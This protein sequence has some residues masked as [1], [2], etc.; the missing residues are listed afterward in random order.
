MLALRL[1]RPTGCAH[2][3]YGACA[4]C[5][6]KINAARVRNCAMPLH[7]ASGVQPVNKKPLRRQSERSGFFVA[8][9]CASRLMPVI[10]GSSDRFIA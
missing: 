5:T 2:N 8:A 6:R 9:Q 7:K 3:Q 10:K 4:L 1:K